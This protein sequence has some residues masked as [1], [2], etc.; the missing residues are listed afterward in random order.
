MSTTLVQHVTV[1]VF[2]TH[3]RSERAARCLRRDSGRGRVAVIAADH[4]DWLLARGMSA[5]EFLLA[6][7]VPTAAVLACDPPIAAG[8]ALL[9][10]HGGEAEPADTCALLRALRAESAEHHE[11]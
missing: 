7:G 5:H 6:L 1:A 8:K 11:V 10:V 4:R 9:V 3:A 2:D